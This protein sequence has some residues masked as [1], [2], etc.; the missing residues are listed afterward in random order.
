[1]EILDFLFH[2]LVNLL[3]SILIVHLYPKVLSLFYNYI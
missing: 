1:M 2:I 3:K